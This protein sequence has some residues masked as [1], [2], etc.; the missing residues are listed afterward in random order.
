MRQAK[1]SKL[2][3]ENGPAL[4]AALE[5]LLNFPQNQDSTEPELFEAIHKAQALV[6]KIRRN[7]LL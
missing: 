6:S 2:A 5:H 3:R 4:L 7:A 1:L